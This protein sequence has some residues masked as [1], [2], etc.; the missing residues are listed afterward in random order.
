MTSRHQARTTADLEF[1]SFARVGIAHTAV[2]VPAG[3]LVDVLEY[4]NGAFD[5]RITI[6]GRLYNLV[7]YDRTLIAAV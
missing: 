5:A 1:D 2:E 6:A 4:P 7:E 3:A